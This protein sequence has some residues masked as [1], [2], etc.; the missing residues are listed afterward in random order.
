MTEPI[1]IIFIVWNVIS[2]LLHA[3]H[4]KNSQCSFK[5]FGIDCGCVTG[6]NENQ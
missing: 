2:F 1:T 5:K 4:I 6:P 3:Y